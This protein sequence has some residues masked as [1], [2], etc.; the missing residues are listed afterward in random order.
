MKG[1]PD[2]GQS[3]PFGAVKSVCAGIRF[4]RAGVIDWGEGGRNPVFKG[5][6]IH[7]SLVDLVEEEF[8]RVWVERLGI[9]PA[10]ANRWVFV[11]EFWVNV[12]RWARLEAVD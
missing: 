10:L 6:R 4:G 3:L 9:G 7:W 12:D 8:L 2:P 5:C 1:I 11:G